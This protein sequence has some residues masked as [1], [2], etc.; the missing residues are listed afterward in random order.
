MIFSLFSCS[1]LAEI[2][3]LYHTAVNG[4]EEERPAAAKILCGASLRSGWNIQVKQ[5]WS[6]TGDLHFPMFQVL[7]YL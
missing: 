1:S 6:N 5:P 3:K 4:S 2:E 7:L